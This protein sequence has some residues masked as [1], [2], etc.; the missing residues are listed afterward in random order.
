MGLWG[1][2]GLRGLQGGQV[3]ADGFCGFSG[4][5]RSS[6]KAARALCTWLQTGAAS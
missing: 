2:W 1:L 3:R 5:G 4:P 6:D